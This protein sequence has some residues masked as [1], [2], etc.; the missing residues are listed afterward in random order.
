MICLTLSGINRRPLVVIWQIQY[1]L[2]FNETSIFLVGKSEIKH[3][4]NIITAF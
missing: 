1:A 2:L 4:K 3:L